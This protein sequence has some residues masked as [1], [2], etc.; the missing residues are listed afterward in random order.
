MLDCMIFY[1]KNYV[2]KQKKTM[3]TAS[4]G[5]VTI[6]LLD[7]LFYCSDKTKLPYN[8]PKGNMTFVRGSLLQ[9]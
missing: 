1:C 5:L 3:E 4:N 6:L 8:G 9:L 7:D 2:T